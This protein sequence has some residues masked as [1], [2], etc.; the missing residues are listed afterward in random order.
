MDPRSPK[1]VATSSRGSPKSLADRTGISTESAARVIERLCAGILLPDVVLPFD[2]A[3]LAGATVADVL[4]DPARFEG[5]TL[6]DPLEGVAYGA[7]KA[8]IMV[9]AGGMPWIHSFAHGRS[10]YELKLDARA[11]ENALKKAPA[12]EI[13]DLFVRLAPNRRS[14]RSRD[15]SAPEHG[16]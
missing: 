7:C 2:D 1:R 3:E 10:V 16:A 5:A 4:A 12:A 14:G 15:R 6:A 11:V 9:R 8:K 13:A